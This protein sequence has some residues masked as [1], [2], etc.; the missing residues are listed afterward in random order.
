M[1]TFVVVLGIAVI[2]AWSSPAMAA[3]DLIYGCCNRPACGK[4]C[5]LICGTTKLT[6]VGYG[7]E[8]KDIC[9]PG[10]SVP[11]CKHCET[12]CCCDSDV[13]GCRPKIEFC[14]YD[15]FTCGCARPRTIRVLTK[16][17]AEKEVPAYHW[18][19]VD[20]CNCCCPC[21]CHCVYK[22]APPDSQLGDVLELT[23]D[24]QAQV[25]RYLAAADA[26]GDSPAAPAADTATG[27]A[28]AKSASGQRLA[29]AFSLSHDAK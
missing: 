23:S 1:R 10:P 18:E 25:T 11:G 28:A 9:I 27:P 14:W 7:C 2:G 21:G 6:A 15:W 5:K 20:G 4:V 26:Q 19:V 17:Q 29:D 8:C 16:Y 24:E 12:R 22:P 3:V 13:K